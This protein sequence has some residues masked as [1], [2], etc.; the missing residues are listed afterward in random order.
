V[1]LALRDCRLVQSKRTGAAF[2]RN[3][4]F[5][6]VTDCYSEAIPPSTQVGIDF[7]PTGRI[8]QRLTPADVI[9][10]SNVRRGAS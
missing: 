3:V 6:R 5:V 2:Q 7:E 9:I 10:D 8:G 1:V 4:E